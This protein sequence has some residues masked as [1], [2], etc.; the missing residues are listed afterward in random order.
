MTEHD[1]ARTV[2]ENCS[3]CGVQPYLGCSNT[4]WDGKEDF[5]QSFYTCPKCNRMG[6][7]IDV[8]T[9]AEAK[10]Q[11]NER[12]RI[13]SEAYKANPPKMTTVDASGDVPQ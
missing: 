10:R 11:W 3:R 1:R 2:L 7:W 4:G 6:P 8:R 9:A 12:Q 5:W 13:I